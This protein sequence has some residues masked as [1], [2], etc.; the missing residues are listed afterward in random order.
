MVAAGSDASAVLGGSLPWADATEQPLGRRRPGA[1]LRRDLAKHRPI[2][3]AALCSITGQVVA[4]VGHLHLAVGACHRDLKLENFVIQGCHGHGRAG[5]EEEMPR[6]R[7]VD[8]DFARVV[9][10]P[11]RFGQSAVAR[12]RCSGKCGTV[13]YVAPEVV[14]ERSYDG[15]AA[16]VWSLGVLLLEVVCG[17][18]ILERVFDLNRMARASGQDKR[19]AEVA[20]ALRCAL[21]EA[22]AVSRLIREHVRQEAKQMLEHGPGCMEELLTN[23][24]RMDP[25]ARWDMAL[26]LGAV[27]TIPGN[28]VRRS[29]TGEAFVED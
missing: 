9:A 27:Q 7:L 17:A 5:S 26:V 18:R 12:Q 6:I 8:F 1:L 22:G 20:E 29:L 14:M 21:S 16:D 24:L 23:M 2:S 11:T 4:A 15:M 13:P 28:L 25:K 10:D 3:T 19:I